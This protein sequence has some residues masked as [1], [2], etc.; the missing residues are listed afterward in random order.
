MSDLV[1]DPEDR[2]SQDEAQLMKCKEIQSLPSPLRT[3]VVIEPTRVNINFGLDGFGV[4]RVHDLEL[5][6]VRPSTDT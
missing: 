6:T 2:F 3:R 5:L 4:G 1:G